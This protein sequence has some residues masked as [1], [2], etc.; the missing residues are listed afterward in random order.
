LRNYKA[1]NAPDIVQVFHDNIGTLVA[2]DSLYD[3]TT[4]LENWKKEDA[5]GYDKILKQAWDM[6]SFKGKP[7]GMAAHVAPYWHVHRTDLFKE[8]NLSVPET[9]DDVIEAADILTDTSKEFYGYSIVGGRAHPP[10]WFLSIFKSMGG[11][12]TATGLP[13]IDSEAGV[14]LLNFYQKLQKNGSLHPETI[15]WSSGEMRGAF[16]GGNTAMIPEADNIYTKINEAMAYEDMW[17]A[18]VQPYRPGAEADRKTALWGWPMVVNKKTSNPEAVKK[19]LQYMID[20]DIVSEV[21]YRYQPTTNTEVTQSAEYVKRKPWAPKFTE[22]LSKTI[23]MPYHIR[24]SEVSNILVDAFQEALQ[25][26]DA[27]AAEMASRYQK[28]LNALDN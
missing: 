24:Q 1:N 3:M 25:K 7:Y 9:W 5:E 8:N 19:V 20:T 10:W 26:P 16:I 23:I 28:L 4:E 11:E 21:A 12:H 14:Y 15:S 2:Q 17:T 6:A 13:M 18:T 27:D 22:E